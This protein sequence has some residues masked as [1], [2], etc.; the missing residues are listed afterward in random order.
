[1]LGGRT[2]ST[3]YII[4]SVLQ[5]SVLGPL[6]LIVYMADLT[7]I[8]EKHGISLHAF[9]DDTQ[10]YLHCR[11]GD[12][13]SASTQLE[14]CIAD[15]GRWMSGNRLKLNTDKTELLWVVPIYSLHQHD[16]C[17]PELH[18]GHD[19]VVAHDHVHLLG[20]TILSDLNLDRHVSKR[21]HL[22]FILAS[23]VAACPAFTRHAVSS[24]TQSYIHS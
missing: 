9:A 18:L 11:R 10:L 14:R 4:C 21:Q 20:A 19:S 15:V 16:L 23:A 3:I 13:A 5:G 24:H 1:M 17:L 2:S 6:L 12:T 22:R 8:V 7:T